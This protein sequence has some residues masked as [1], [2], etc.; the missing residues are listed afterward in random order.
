MFILTDGLFDEEEQKNILNEVE[1][2]VF[3]NVE[4]IGIGI[5]VYPYGIKYLFPY[6][7]YSLNPLNVMF[8][9]SEVTLNVFGLFEIIFLII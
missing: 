3:N 5:G 4:I 6:I 7:I 9:C 2:C 1:N 8:G